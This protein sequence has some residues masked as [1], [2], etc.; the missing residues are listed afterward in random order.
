[1]KFKKPSPELC[2]HLDEVMG[3]FDVQKRK[4][5]GSP[6][7]F[8]NRNMFCGVHQD[9][10]FMRLSEGDREK[11]LEEFDE[12][13]IFEPMEGRKMKEYIAV[14]EAVYDDPETFN[15]WLGKS[16]EYVSSLPV[17]PEKKSKKK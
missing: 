7:Y 12:A 17:K 2:Q 4:M 10:I 13:Q 16:F 15:S 3:S 6:V 11:L 8:V 9:A 1:M 14:P 5:F